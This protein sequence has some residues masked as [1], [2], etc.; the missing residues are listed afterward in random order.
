MVH[1]GNGS[2]CSYVL[3]S[4]V[5]IISVFGTEG[6]PIIKNPAHKV[7]FEWLAGWLTD[8]NG[9]NN[10][11]QKRF[12]FNL[13]LTPC[14]F[15]DGKGFYLL[16]LLEVPLHSLSLSSTPSYHT[17]FFFPSGKRGDYVLTLFF[18]F[19]LFL[20]NKFKHIQRRKIVS[21][22]ETAE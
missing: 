22:E 1:N 3:C 17:S 8:R 6:L 2:I 4:T 18:F 7:A 16:A 9:P 14:P 21:F 15:L 20:L 19:F 5:K 12:S 13:W 10:F 11:A